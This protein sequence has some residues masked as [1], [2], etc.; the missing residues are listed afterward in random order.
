MSY[1]FLVVL[2]SLLVTTSCMKKLADSDD[3]GP[4]VSAES[5]QDSLIQAWGDVDP[6]TI[7]KNEFAYF[8]REQKIQDED[9]VTILQEGITV[10][11][12]QVGSDEIVYTLLHQIN[13]LSNGSSKLSTTEEQVSVDLSGTSAM[14]EMALAAQSLNKEDSGVQQTALGVQTMQSLVTACVKDTD[15]DVECHNLQ[16]SETTRPAPDLVKDQANCLGLPDCQIRVRNVSF[17]L[18]LNVKNDDGTTSRQ[19]VQYWVAVSPDVPYL[20]R[21][22]D[23]CYRGLVDVPSLG[24]KVLVQTCSYVKNFKPGQ[25]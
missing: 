18:V 5:V 2:L 11:D 23:F 15:W 6:A 25:N 9:P 1:R 21:L 7:Q 17:D 20:S 13:D 14:K 19:K 8:E 24:Q 3:D 16:Y 12:R 10:S 4:A 22:M